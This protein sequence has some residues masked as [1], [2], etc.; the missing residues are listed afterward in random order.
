MYIYSTMKG[1][2]SD[3]R[4]GEK[5][6]KEAFRPTKITI[7]RARICQAG[8]EQDGQVFSVGH[9][10]RV[11]SWTRCGQVGW[12]LAVGGRRLA[13]GLAV[14]WSLDWPILAPQTPLHLSIQIAKTSLRRW[15]HVTLRPLPLSGLGWS[16]WCSPCTSW[17]LLRLGRLLGWSCTWPSQRLSSRPQ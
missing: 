16:L 5:A 4:V 17:A 2:H 15:E 9:P 14:A 11:G 10:D 3:R 7:R 13:V 8:S 12:R 6:Q 1:L